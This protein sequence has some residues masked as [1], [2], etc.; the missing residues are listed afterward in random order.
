MDHGHIIAHGSPKE[1]VGQLEVDSCIEF[2]WMGELDDQW[3]RSLPG[4]TRVVLDN[5]RSELFSNAPQETLTALL[6]LSEKE[7]FAIEDL[8]IRRAT[9]EDLFIEL[10]GRRLRE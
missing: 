7:Q 1:L 10:T 5:H 6:R 3:C 4:V 9:L 2:S 8:H